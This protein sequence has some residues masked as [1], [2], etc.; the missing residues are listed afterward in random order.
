MKKMRYVLLAAVL[1]LGLTGCA[2]PAA[3]KAAFSSRA[4][5]FCSFSSS[6][7]HITFLPDSIGKEP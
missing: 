5:F 7:A 4:R 1:C 3:P 6:L 2:S